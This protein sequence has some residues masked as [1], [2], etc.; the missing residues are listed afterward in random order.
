MNISK[1]TM[2]I[3]GIVVILT[4]ALIIGRLHVSQK[5]PDIVNVPAITTQ[6]LQPYFPM[7]SE[8]TVKNISKQITYAKENKAPQYHYYTTTQEA[9]DQEA[10]KY[11]Q[12]Q[13][14]D[15]VV[16]ETH[17][18]EVETDTRETEPKV[19]ENNYYAISLERKHRIKVGAATVD[20]DTYIK[21]AYQNRDI[22]YELYHSPKTGA[23]GIGAEVTI[24]KW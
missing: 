12:Q 13:K 20:G 6:N 23:I 18:V 3:A 10:Q 17:K 5:K 8:S 1:K 11:A 21:A 9:A 4:V 15:K 14:A 7:E 2:A 16:K 22:E 24:V 19:I